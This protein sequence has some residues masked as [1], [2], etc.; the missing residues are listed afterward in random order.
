[1]IGHSIGKDLHL[2]ILLV[3]VM[4]LHIFPLISTLC[5]LTVLLPLHLL[6]AILL[7]I[8]LLRLFEVPVLCTPQRRVIPSAQSLRIT[9]LSHAFDKMVFHGSRPSELAIAPWAVKA[10]LLPLVFRD[11][12]L[13]VSG[14][15]FPSK[16]I[17]LISHIYMIYR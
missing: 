16:T 8:D 2:F 11:R 3:L 9:V 15:T 12:W 13:E 6:V 14:V 7:L 17:R 5:P 10:R 1:M 4:V